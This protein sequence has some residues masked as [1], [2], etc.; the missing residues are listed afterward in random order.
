MPI[1]NLQETPDHRIRMSFAYD[2][3]TLAFVKNT[4]T[5]RQYDGNTKSWLIPTTDQ[6]LEKIRQNARRF[7]DIQDV[8]ERVQQRKAAVVQASQAFAASE[9]FQIC[10]LYTSPSPRD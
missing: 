4:F 5:G 2:A 9:N 6:N 1:I 3:D 7:G 8:L 10:L